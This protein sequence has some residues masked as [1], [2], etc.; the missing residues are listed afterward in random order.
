MKKI[1]LFFSI[2]T[3]GLILID[4]FGLVS[5]KYCSYSCPQNYD[6]IALNWF[7]ISGVSLMV[8]LILSFAPISVYKNWWKF[9]RIAIPVIFIISTAINL[10]LHHHPGS[11]MNMDDIF[12]IPAHILMYSIF[13]I[14][15]CIQIWRGYK[16]K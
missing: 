13:I 11:I 5:K 2:T 12:D 7:F 6:G 9:A 8:V 10:Q 3:I 4:Y 14:G 1:T 16:Q 15:S